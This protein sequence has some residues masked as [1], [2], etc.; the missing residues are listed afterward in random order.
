[1]AS[2]PWQSL[3]KPSR[4]IYDIHSLRIATGVRVKLLGWI[5]SAIEFVK[6]P[7]GP[8]QAGPPPDAPPEIAGHEIDSRAAPQGGAPQ[9][10]RP[11]IRIEV[12]PE[13]RISTDTESRAVVE[14]DSAP[15]PEE[16]DRRRGMVRAFFNDY[17]S[18]VEEKPTSFAERLDR[19]EGY[20]NERVAAGGETWRLGAATRKQLGLPPSKKA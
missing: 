6:V 2:I 20:I 19:A 18:T 14:S 12:A 7:A 17:W 9:D 8:R 13:S 15:D 4:V 5:K 11:E 16:I 10:I 1:M 3:P